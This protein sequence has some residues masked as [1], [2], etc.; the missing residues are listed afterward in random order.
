MKRISNLMCGL[1]LLFAACQSEDAFIDSPVASGEGNVNF[2]VSVP[3]VLETTRATLGKSSNSARGGITNV[4]FTK[5]DL[6][7]QLAVYRVDGE[8]ESVTYTQV[9]SP[10]RKIVDNYQSVN[11]SL[12]LTPNRTYRFVVWADFVMQG[13]DTDLHYDTGSFENITCKDEVDEQLNDESR[14]AYF[15]TEEVAVG[16]DGIMKDFVLKRPFAKIRIVTT[17]WNIGK[18]EMPDNFKISYYGCKRFSSINVLT[19]ISES[20][21]LGESGSTLVYSGSIDKEEKEYADNYDQGEHNRTLV[22]DYLMADLN[23]QTPIHFTFEA[24]DGA[25]PISSHNLNTDIPIQRNWLTTVI[26]NILTTDAQFTISIDENFENDWI[27]GEE[28]WNTEILTPKEPRYDEA[29]KTYRIYTK[30]E[31]AW[32]PDHILDM[33]TEV[34]DAGNRVSKGVTILLENDI[35]MSGIEWKPIYTSGEPTYTVDG[36]GHVLRNFSMN[37]KF[38][39]VYEYSALGGLIKLKYNAYTGVWGKFEG[40]MKNLIFENIT[41][42]GLANDEVHTDVEG[43]PIDHSKEYAYFAGC[44]GYTGANYSTTAQFENVHAKHIHVKASTGLT[45]QNIG[46][47][48]GWIGVGGGAT[49]MDN[50][51]VN[52]VHLTG[53]QAGGLVG[54]I[55]GGRGIA[56]KNCLSENVYIRMRSRSGI[57]G[58]VGQYNDGAGSR[59]ENCVYP[60]YVEYLDDK[61]GAIAEYAPE[62]NFFGRCTKNEDKIV[63]ISSE[64]PEP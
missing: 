50:C 1:C 48:I 37:G 7:Y 20:E 33:V 59:I 3:E 19:G 10:Q 43:N 63:I 44:I 8:G 26:G 49:W 32:L 18:L 55:V 35:D 56:I 39:A 64:V 21:D 16:A 11:Y 12:R 46:G 28:W 57:S 6:R 14:D 60:T 58:F 54:Q 41:I 13:T 4:D 5:Y 23:E 15:I 22:V 61:E 51:S 45:T 30:D 29:T 17:D 2:M 40:V 31:F 36:Q 62:N 34:N 47:L 24:L 25:V 42:N 52:D 38:G 9:I 27:E 53:Y